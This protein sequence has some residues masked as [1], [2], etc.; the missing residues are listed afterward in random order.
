MMGETLTE[1]RARVESLSTVDGSF[2]VVCARTGER[3]VPV[4]E[5]RYPDRETA[6]QAATAARRYRATLRRYDPQVAFHDLVVQEVGADHP[7]RLG[8]GRTRP[9]VTTGGDRSRRSAFCHEVT[10]ASF[11]ALSATG[12]DDVEREVMDT[13]MAL[14]DTTADPDDLC[15][16]LLWS[17]TA[18][19]ARLAPEDRERVVRTAASSL[20]PAPASD[21]LEATCSRLREAAVVSGYTVA[22]DPDRPAVRDV[23][24]EG[25]ALADHSGRLPTLPVAVDVLRR[26]AD[27]LT[28]TA[29]AVLPDGRWRLTVAAADATDAGPATGL[30]SLPAVDRR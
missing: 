3:P 18:E 1:L 10:A 14:A 8:S 13:Y 11:E 22:A 26:A 17:L 30:V 19:V 16:L 5:A 7:T 21:P 27:D 20:S 4:D 2:A 29:A 9:P 24:L 15:L 12:H 28:F 23:L 6:V 25:Y